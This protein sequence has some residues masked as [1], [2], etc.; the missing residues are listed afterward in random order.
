VRDF[1]LDTQTVRYWHDSR[2]AQHVAVGG[3]VSS[4][5]QLAEPMEVK[6]RLLISVVTLGEIE[7]GHQVALAPDPAAQ[8]AYIQFVQEVVI[9]AQKGPTS[10]QKRD[11]PGRGRSYQGG[12]GVVP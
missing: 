10:A 5:R 7:F 2:C 4:L 11:P 6:P 3:N 8:A 12:R 1:L 9:G